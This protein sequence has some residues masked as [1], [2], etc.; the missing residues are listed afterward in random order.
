MLFDPAQLLLSV[1]DVQRKLEFLGTLSASLARE[2]PSV[3][4]ETNAVSDPSVVPDSAV[5]YWNP[6]PSSS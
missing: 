1:S 3:F 5:H 4:E 2:L 6:Q